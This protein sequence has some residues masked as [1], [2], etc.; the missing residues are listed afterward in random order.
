M[1]SF[2]DES[3]NAQAVQSLSGDRASGNNLRTE[4]KCKFE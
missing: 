2:L 4:M 1:N 3:G